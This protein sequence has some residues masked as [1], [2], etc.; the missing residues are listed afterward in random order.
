MYPNSKLNNRRAR[1]LTREK[2]GIFTSSISFIFIAFHHALL[3]AVPHAAG[4]E[5]SISPKDEGGWL[6]CVGIIFSFCCAVA[7]AIRFAVVGL[8]ERNINRKYH[9]PN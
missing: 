8:G 7:F 3:L 9:S 2:G 6:S 5:A 1:R 4:K